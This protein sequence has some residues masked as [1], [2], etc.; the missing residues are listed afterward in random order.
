VWDVEGRRITVG[1]R[2]VQLRAV[3]GSSGLGKNGELNK[4]RFIG[5]AV[6]RRRDMC[7]CHGS[8]SWC[9]EISRKIDNFL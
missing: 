4:T 1:V 3:S 7:H 5:F 8:A 2:G 9:K 6:R